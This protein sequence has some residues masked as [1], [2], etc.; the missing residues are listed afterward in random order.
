VCKKAAGSALLANES[1]V[2]LILQ[3][4]VNAVD[5]P[6]TVK[7]RTGTT[8]E[9]RNAVSI[10]RIAEDAGV[11]A[12]SVHGRTRECKFSGQVEYDTIANVKQ[13]V[14]IPVIAN[15]DICSPETAKKVIEFT[16]ADA[17]MIG[18]AAQGQPWLFKQ[19]ADYLIHDSYQ[20]IPKAEVRIKTI[21]DHLE[22]IHSFY[23]EGLGL[24]LA[25]KH[26]KWYLAHWQTEISSKLQRQISTTE[27]ALQQRQLLEQFLF[28][29]CHQ[30]AA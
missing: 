7:I 25:R 9:T 17:I 4:V 16:K 5:V 15:G 8:P 13:S 22:N 21:L 20:E 27:N 2:E 12:I 14:A 29:T 26:I 18:R 28:Q 6:V 11:S 1:L 10:A 3:T 23:G 30:L 24:R 19:V